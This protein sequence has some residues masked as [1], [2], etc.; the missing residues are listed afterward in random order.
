MLGTTGGISRLAPSNSAPRRPWVAGGRV[1]A[2]GVWLDGVLPCCR[3]LRPRTRALGPSHSPTHLTRSLPAPSPPLPPSQT[4]GPG[5]GGERRRDAAQGRDMITRG[6]PFCP[7]LPSTPL[8]RRHAPSPRSPGLD[9]VGSGGLGLASIQEGGGGRAS[10][11]HPSGCAAS[12]E[13][14]GPQTAVKRVLQ[15]N[16]ALTSCTRVLRFF[17]CRW[18]T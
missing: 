10:W 3:A 11:T 18:G 17:A 2:G 12:E 8:A 6:A 13:Y 7:S 15:G 1:S 4:R 5:K 9:E 16:K 14:T